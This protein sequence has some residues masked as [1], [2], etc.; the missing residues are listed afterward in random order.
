MIVSKKM[1]TEFLRNFIFGTVIGASMLIPGVSGGTTAIILGIYDKLITAVSNIFKKP[2]QSFALLIPVACGGIVGAALFSGAVLLLIESFYTQSMFFFIGAILG[3]IP[4]LVKRSGITLST[5]YH[6]VFALI[7]IVL[8]MALRFLPES[9]GTDGG[10]VM[11]IVCGFII[12]AAMVL[13]GISTSHVLLVMGMY[14]TVWGG[15]HNMDVCFLSL[16]GIGGIAGTILTAKAADKAMEKF[17]CQT[18]MMIIGFV[19]TSVYDIYPQNTELLQLPVDIVLCAAGFLLVL[20]V[21][22]AA[23]KRELKSI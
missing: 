20:F 6:A 18:Y 7:G 9:A 21:S 11:L 19:M 15:L 2:K 10:G 23:S 1:I 13:P 14:E 3:C 8:V 17:P 12:A 16:L 5:L 22:S 4:F